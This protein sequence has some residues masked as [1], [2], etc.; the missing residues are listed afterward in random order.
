MDA[1]QTASKSHPRSVDDKCD[2]KIPYYDSKEMLEPGEMPPE[3]IPRS[4][5][6]RSMEPINVTMPRVVLT[7]NRNFFNN[8][9][10]TSMSSVHVPTNVFARGLFRSQLFALN[11]F[12]V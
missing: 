2:P 11:L 1:A 10:N 6:D 3:P 12:S 8:R 7:E 5:D 4:I 9:I